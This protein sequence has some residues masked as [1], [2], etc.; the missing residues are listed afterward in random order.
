MYRVIIFEARN[1]LQFISSLEKFILLAGVILLIP[2]FPITKVKNNTKNI[3]G[4]V[5]LSGRFMGHAGVDGRQSVL[6]VL[7]N[8]MFVSFLVYLNILCIIRI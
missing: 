6:S 2:N 3:I 5:A 1:A 8:W 4:I 7:Q